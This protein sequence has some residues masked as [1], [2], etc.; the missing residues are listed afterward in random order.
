MIRAILCDFGK[1]V[2]RTD[3]AAV[4]KDIQQRFHTH[5]LVGNNPASVPAYHAVE[6][7]SA[8]LRPV[9][10]QL[11][12]QVQSAELLVFYQQSYLKHRTLNEKLLTLLQQLKKS[13]LLY[14][15]TDTNATHLEVN[16]TQ[17]FFTLFTQVFASCELGVTKDTPR[18]FDAVLQ[19]IRIPPAAC[20]FIDDTLKNIAIAQARGLRVIHYTTFPE[21]VELERALRMQGVRW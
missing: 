13:T 21:T 20:L 9:F 15:F 8:G 17:E 5:V 16:R 2:F 7:S 18:A 3:W 1:V 19:Y 6:I 14:G 10:Q 4:D 12:P 11:A